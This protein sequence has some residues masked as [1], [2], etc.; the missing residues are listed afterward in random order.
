MLLFTSAAG[1]CSKLAYSRVP[2]KPKT[3]SNKPRLANRATVSTLNVDQFLQHFVATRKLNAKS[4]I[5][6][7][8]GDL[9]VP[10]GGMAWVETIAQA[11]EPIGI[12]SRLVRTSLFRLS[13]EGWL[14]GTRSGRKSYYQLT[15]KGLSQTR[16]AEKL[17]YYSGRKEWDGK[18]TLVF[19]VLGPLDIH[20]RKQLE[21]ELTWIGF[22]AVAK[23]ILAHPTVMYETVAERVKSLGMSQ[24][25]VCMRAE[26]LCDANIGLGID[27]KT[28]A[29]SCFPTA[30]LQTHY[31]AFIKTFSELDIAAIGECANKSSLLALR[32]VL[33]DEY[34]RIILHDPHLPKE[35]LPHDWIGSK[36]YHLCQKLYLKLLPE[37]D[38]FYRE[39][40]VDECLLKSFDS[41]YDTRFND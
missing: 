33:L 8:F 19:I 13:E 31:H 35:L 29:T 25:V 20:A 37:T 30:E 2:L 40:F 41:S 10:H 18:W 17:I 15:E 34:R 39:L 32:L 3:S 6:T 24:S 5:S 38:T 16:L 28:L 27:D 22:G 14:A 21:Q 11:L 1:D 36:A 9:V 12:N 23:H 7:F 26:N 4:L